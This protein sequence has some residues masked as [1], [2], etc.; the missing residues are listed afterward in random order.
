M[1][2]VAPWSPTPLAPG[3]RPA[4]S[5]AT[6]SVLDAPIITSQ[7]LSR[8]NTAGTTATFTVSVAGSGALS[9]QWF[10]NSTPIS[11]ATGAG[12]IL[13]HVSTSDAAGYS[14]I[15]TDAAGSAASSIATLRRCF[16]S[17]ADQRPANPWV[18]QPRRGPRSPLLPSSHDSLSPLSYEWIQNGTNRLTDGGNISGSGTA[19]LTISNVLGGDTGEYSVLV[20][21]SVGSVAGSPA[22]LT[23]IDPVITNQPVS[24]TQTAGLPVQF[25]VGVAG[26]SPV[27]QWLKNALPIP[28][29][30][31]ATLNLAG[32]SDADAAD[33][34]VVV[35]NAFGMSISSVATLQVVDALTILSQPVNQIGSPGAV[36]SFSR[37]CGGVGSVDLPMAERFAADQ[38]SQRGHADAEQRRGR[39]H[40]RI[41]RDRE[42]PRRQR[43]ERDRHVDR[44]G[45]SDDC[46]PAFELHQLCRHDGNLCRDCR[47]PGASDLSMA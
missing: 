38:R 47:W 40:G 9:Y 11:G 14:V 16:E 26:T 30:T 17:A 3:A 2:L 15:V 25:S 8:T 37:G 13:A 33:Y 43:H 35:S 10:K 23:V 45:N 4:L 7:P 20:G 27:Y 36:A 6:L 22:S 5:T 1:R 18:D 24:V 44:T 12:L 21:N 28:G 39:G 46:K 31:S 29:A 42:Q 41:Q 19:S 32:V 34:S